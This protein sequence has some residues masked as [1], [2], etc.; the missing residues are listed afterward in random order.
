LIGQPF[1]TSEYVSTYLVTPRYKFSD[2]YMVYARYSTGYR[3]GGFNRLNRMLAVPA[4]YPPYNADTSKNYELGFKGTLL[5]GALT[6]D[7][8]VYRIDWN[9]IQIQITPP[10]DFFPIT[11]N[12]GVAKSQG[13][14]LSLTARPW[15]GMEL[16]G[17]VTLSNAEL[18]EDFPI[19]SAARGLK[20][21]K[22]PVSSKVSGNLSLTQEFPVSR[23]LTG[24]VGGTYTYVGD[25]LGNFTGPDYFTGIVPPRDRFP[26]Y[27]TVELRAGV[28]NELWTVSLHAANVTDQR[29][30]IY[31]DKDYLVSI[32]PREI[33][34]NVSRRF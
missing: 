12:G 28:R 27:D 7:A 2:D 3:P 24:F 20:G 18:A 23:N 1:E 17:W 16:S 13:V 22:L 6:V 5:G 33:G 15:R 26:S 30:I 29:G 4:P 19:A 11:E 34:L 9:D 31:G 25:R 10:G 21:D 8:S 32:K 14:E